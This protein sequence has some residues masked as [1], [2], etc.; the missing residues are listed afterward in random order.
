MNSDNGT[1]FDEHTNLAK[2]KYYKSENIYICNLL[3][4]CTCIAHLRY[5]CPHVAR[6]CLLDPNECIS[7]KF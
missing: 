2:K 3:S 6:P 1:S 4:I 7:T 5:K